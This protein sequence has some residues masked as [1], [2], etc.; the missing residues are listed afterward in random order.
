MRSL[1]DSP[2]SEDDDNN[3]TGNNDDQQQQPHT[4]KD[5]N[6]RPSICINAIVR[7]HRQQNSNVNCLVQWYQYESI[8]KYILCQLNWP[9]DGLG[10]SA[11]DDALDTIVVEVLW[12]VNVLVVDVG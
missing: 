2:V 11:F 9:F 7:V 10:A 6:D 5:S 1:I 3:N 4:E 12:A 8:W